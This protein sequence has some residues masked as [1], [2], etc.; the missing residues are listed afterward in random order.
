MLM[1]NF[2]VIS[3]NALQMKKCGIRN[4]LEVIYFSIHSF[5]Q[6]FDTYY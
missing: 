4:P 2:P 6:N 1:Y 3:K 5:L